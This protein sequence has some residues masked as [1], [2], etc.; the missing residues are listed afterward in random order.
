MTWTIPSTRF[1]G[2]GYSLHRTR[3]FWLGWICTK[4]YQLNWTF[5]V[6]L[7][8]FAIF[9]REFHEQKCSK[10]R[11]KTSF[12][13]LRFG[14]KAQR[15]DA[16]PYVAPHTTKYTRPKAN[17]YVCVS[18]TH[19]SLQNDEYAVWYGVVKTGYNRSSSALCVCVC[20]YTLACAWMCLYACMCAYALCL[21]ACE[22][23]AESHFNVLLHTTAEIWWFPISAIAVNGVRDGIERIERL[24]QK[25][26]GKQS[27]ATEPRED[28]EWRRR[29]GSKWACFYDYV[30]GLYWNRIFYWKCIL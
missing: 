14:R 11:S 30:P 18:H 13:T 21:Y 2:R 6:C 3:L 25:E 24:R 29:R 17:V 22:R 7:F 26:N 28:S 12:A 4:L 20:M 19:P 8:V 1:I 10:I 16:L 9:L 5:C 15:S 23:A 27:A